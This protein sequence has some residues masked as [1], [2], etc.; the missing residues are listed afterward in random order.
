MPTQSDAGTTVAIPPKCD[1]YALRG[2]QIE[3]L[4]AAASAIWPVGARTSAGKLGR[5]GDFSPVVSPNRMRGDARKGIIR[6]FRLRRRPAALALRSASS[7]WQ[8]LGCRLSLSSL[9][10][11]EMVSLELQHYKVRLRQSQRVRYRLLRTVLRTAWGLASL[12][13][14]AISFVVR[15]SRTFAAY[16]GTFS[17]TTGTFALAAVPRVRNRR[18]L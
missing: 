1:S 11:G 5:R 12:A 15:A 18:R 10:G 9:L 3:L 4:V 17:R 2:E 7:V 16:A 6:R 13:S 14:T 8:T